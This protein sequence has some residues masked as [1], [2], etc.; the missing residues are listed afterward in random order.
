[1]KM[2][3]YKYKKKKKNRDKTWKYHEHLETKSGK[4]IKDL[5][6][7]VVHKNL[8]WFLNA[9]LDNKCLPSNWSILCSSSFSDKQQCWR[10][11]ATTTTGEIF[12]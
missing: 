10:P 6:K 4:Q 12:C 2:Y 8:E 11:T 1:M 5:M 3:V 9:T 7:W